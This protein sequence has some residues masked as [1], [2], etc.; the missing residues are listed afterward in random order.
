[1]EGVI[2][3]GLEGK[4]GREHSPVA[5]PSS[6][7]DKL[8]HH[9][10]HGARARRDESVRDGTKEVLSRVMENRRAK[11]GLFLALKVLCCQLV[12][13]GTEP[14]RSAARKGPSK[15]RV[16]AMSVAVRAVG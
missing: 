10:N 8:A 16:W 12:V 4:T 7:F 9:G 15:L 3:P 1:M 5:V 13:F 14:E 2:Q 6:S 11:L